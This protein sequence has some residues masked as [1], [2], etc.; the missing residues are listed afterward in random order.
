VPAPAALDVLI[1]GE[2]A[3]ADLP[4]LLTAEGAQGRPARGRNGFARQK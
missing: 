3:G 2:G 1:D 4:A